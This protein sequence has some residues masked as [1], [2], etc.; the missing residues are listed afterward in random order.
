MYVFVYG[1][2][3]RGHGNHYWMPEDAELIG[4]DTLKN[5]NIYDLGPFPAVVPEIGEYVIGELW[6]VESLEN[7]DILEGY[8]ELY[9]RKVV[10]TQSGYDAWVYYMSTINFDTAKSVD[11]KEW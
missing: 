2:L 7:L 11:G 10:K 5:F 3:K 1:T 9:N 4:K 6:E 8:P